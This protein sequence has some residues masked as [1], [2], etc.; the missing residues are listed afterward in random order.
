MA[1]ERFD[2]EVRDVVSKSI[3]TELRAIGTE[4]RSTHNLVQQMNREL[5][6]GTR[7]AANT[8]R[9][10]AAQAASAAGNSAAA[11]AKA[12]AETARAA[13]MN[14]K[15]SISNER[16]AQSE[17]RTA[18]AKQKL[19]TEAAKTATAQSRA[20]VAYLQEEAALNRAV[21]A[22]QRAIT[23]K[24][25]LAAASDTAAAAV[26]REIQI[27]DGRRSVSSAGDSWIGGRAGDRGVAA[28]QSEAMRS[29]TPAVDSNTAALERNASAAVQTAAAQN[30]AATAAKDMGRNMGL[31]SQHAMNLS[32]QL[33]DVFVSLASGQSVWMV[34]MQQGAQIQQI[35]QQAGLS[36]RQMGKEALLMTRILKQTTEAEAAAELASASAAARRLQ[37]SAAMSA[38]AL[39]QADT[40]VAL[41]LAQRETATT[42]AQVAAAEAR[43]AK[44]HQSAAT[45]A[46]EQTVAENALAV[47]QG[48]QATASNAATRATTTRLGAVGRIAV[49]LAAAT[50]AVGVSL[51]ALNREAN[52]TSDLEAY[53]KSLGLTAKEI[54]QLDDV[55]VTYGDTAKAVFQVGI[56]RVA[57]ALGINAE[58]ISTLWNNMLN[59]MASAT[60][61]VLAGIYAT[62][63]GTYYS[64]QNVLDAYKKGD[65]IWDALNDPEGY[66][67]AREEAMAFFDDVSAQSVVNAQN[68]IRTQAQD[69]G[70]LDPET[71][72]SA[73]KG[74]A[75]SG[76][77]RAAE[78]KR[79]NDELDSQITLLQYYGDELE[80]QTQLEQIARRF[81]EEGVPL[82]AAEN[83]ALM[84]KITTLQEG[85]RVQQA[86]TAAAEAAHGPLKTLTAT[87][88]ALN[89]LL[90]AGA[91]DLAEH[92][93][94]MRMAERTYEDATNPLAA[95]NR[96]L[97]RNGELVSY[98]GRN[99]GLREYI[100][101]LKDAAEAQG[102]SIYD[103]QPND[104]R[105]SNDNEIVINGS[106]RYTQDAQDMIDEYKRQAEAAEMTQAFERIDPE[107]DKDVGGT[108]YILDNYRRMYDEIQRFREEDVQNEEE[109]QR[110]KKNIDRAL[111][112]ARLET[113]SDMFGQLATLQNSSVKEVA[114]IGKAAAIAQA[115]IDGIAAVQAALAGPPGPPW[116]F[117]IAGTTAAMTAAN[118]A[119]IAG[120][121]FQRGGYTGDG[122][123]NDVAGPAHRQEYVFDA[124]ATRRIGVPALEALRSGRT[125]GPGQNAGNSG[126]GVNRSV[127]I[128]Q[129]SVRVEGKSDDPEATGAAVERGIS[130]AVK[131]LTRDEI[132]S[133][134]RDG[135]LLSDD[136]M[137]A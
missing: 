86:M 64:I 110:R 68:R 89:R 19:A 131:Q 122:N 99:R 22:E 40:E 129:I 72:G 115:T 107:S 47:A 137:A 31:T 73:K 26:K 106:R 123:P 57:E 81:R 102:K 33:N 3:R 20:N 30:R 124:A 38:S 66:N 21:S 7:A 111:T 16:L 50:A 62:F 121:G 70:Y 71:G 100:N 127:H 55:T 114:A 65:S 104:P 44:A 135:G 120:I 134:Q 34:A 52:N 93:R 117:A 60:K 82:T 103:V 42:A 105:A 11:Q 97:E 108:A 35:N 14:A 13:A 84:T 77:D 37:A 10:A 32:F 112:Q 9:T 25:K 15:A 90:D 80:R 63:A 78:L 59:N 12:T 23:S 69:A 75:G 116:S 5:A 98:Y 76:F 94:Q 39:A 136:V 53:A 4:A 17:L 58:E 132:R 54:A 24:Q 49:P 95:L 36:W 67:K 130:R 1:T 109:A 8:A 79:V 87:Q 46:A 133:Q 6:A 119:R 29:A 91:I 88:E 92:N 51:A 118:V 56:A 83:A 27:T 85:A 28:R 41:A 2:I 113:A 43:L 125:F 101:Q 61:E 126:M 74:R 96:E 48:R 45:A 128:G 18:L